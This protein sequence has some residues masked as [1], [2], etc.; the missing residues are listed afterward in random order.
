MI[1]G[2]RAWLVLAV[3]VALYEI[4]APKDQLLSEAVDRWLAKR[5][6]MTR[7]VVVLTAAHLLNLI[8]QR[9]DPFHRLAEASF[10]RR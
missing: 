8:P 10:W 4:A 7:A 5:P 6:W 3:A 1:T 9:V 2:E